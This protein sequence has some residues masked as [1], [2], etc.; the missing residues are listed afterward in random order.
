[1]TTT[2]WYGKEKILF[3][4]RQM[5]QRKVDVCKI[6]PVN[7]GWLTGAG[8]YDV[9]QEVAMWAESN[10]G[11]GD[12]DR[13]QRSEWDERSLNTDILFVNESGEAFMITLPYLRAIPIQEDVWATGSGGDLATGA[14]AA[15]G[16]ILTAMSV[17]HNYDATTGRQFDVIKIED[18]AVNSYTVEV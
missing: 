16:D 2:V 7:N 8:D 1:M 6:I 11:F 10:G 17:A 4:D 12:G 3:S 5:G 14:L 9:L 18:A 15:S 13:P